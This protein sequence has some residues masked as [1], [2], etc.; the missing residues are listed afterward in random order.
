MEH[1]THSFIFLNIDSNKLLCDHQHGFQSNCNCETQLTDAENDFFM[2]LN[3]DEH[4]DALF[5]DFVEAFDKMPHKRLC[6]KLS[7]YGINE[8]LLLWIKEF[9]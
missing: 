7:H 5:L 8:I 2:C 6:Y 9:L 4:I 1:I 3:N